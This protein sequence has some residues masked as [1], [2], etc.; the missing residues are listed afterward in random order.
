[1]KNLPKNYM[2]KEI[3]NLNYKPDDFHCGTSKRFELFK[4]TKDNLYKTTNR[5]YGVNTEEEAI[6]MVL[7][8]IDDLN[9]SSLRVI[10]Y[11][12]P[13]PLSKA[14]LEAYRGGDKSILSDY[15]KKLMKKQIQ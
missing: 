7:N 9:P 8:K 3:K 5:L 15:I 1:M 6:E 10:R 13:T 2:F 14:E 4:L 12:L 11:K